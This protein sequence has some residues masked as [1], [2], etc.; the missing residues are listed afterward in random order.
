MTKLRKYRTKPLTIKKISTILISV[1]TS[2]TIKGDS[3]DR[4]GGL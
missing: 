1:D 3:V 4:V 2:S